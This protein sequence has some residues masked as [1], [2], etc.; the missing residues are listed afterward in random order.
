MEN[1][2]QFDVKS[3]IIVVLLLLVIFCGMQW[4]KTATQLRHAEQTIATFQQSIQNWQDDIRSKHP[5]D[6][7]PENPE[8]K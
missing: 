2:N 4:L 7:T 8:P 6:V 5:L 1:E 3:V